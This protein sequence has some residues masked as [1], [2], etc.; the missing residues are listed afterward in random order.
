M[1]AEVDIDIFISEIE[2]P[3]CKTTLEKSPLKKLLRDFFFEPPP[4][5]TRHSLLSF[6]VFLY[7]SPEVTVTSLHPPRLCR[8]AVFSIP[9]L[10]SADQKTWSMPAPPS[11]DTTKKGKKHV[12]CRRPPP[13]AE[14]RSTPSGFITVTVTCTS[15][16]QFPGTLSERPRSISGKPRWAQEFPRPAAFTAEDVPVHV[17]RRATQE[18][19]GPFLSTSAGASRGRS[20]IPNLTTDGLLPA[21]PALLGPRYPLYLSRGTGFTWSA[22]PKKKGSPLCTSA[23]APA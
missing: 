13:A 15:V 16:A 17:E 23:H 4:N 12:A 18:A 11:R 2:D 21:L 14:R 5:V 20:S 8:L 10:L 9:T 3:P 22:L 6:F 19:A 1:T 7:V